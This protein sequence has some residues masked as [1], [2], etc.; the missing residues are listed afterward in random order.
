MD[1]ALAFVETFQQVL[2]GENGIALYTIFVGSVMFIGGFVM[3]FLFLL[4]DE[5]IRWVLPF[6]RRKM[7]RINN[8]IKN[9][10]GK[11]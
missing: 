10:K 5:L 3:C 11:D 8:S 1:N 6:F 7:D 9:K 2:S 4:F